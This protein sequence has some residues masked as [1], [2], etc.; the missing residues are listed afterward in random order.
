MLEHPSP[1]PLINICYIWC[2]HD[3]SAHCT[4]WG[5]NTWKL[6][7]LMGQVF[8]LVSFD[9]MHCVR[10]TRQNT[11][12]LWFT[13]L[14]LFHKIWQEVENI[15]FSRKLTNENFW[16]FQICVAISQISCFWK[17]LTP[18]SL[19]TREI[20]GTFH[21]CR[22]KICYLF[23]G[24]KPIL[25]QKNYQEKLSFGNGFIKNPP[26]PLFFLPRVFKYHIKILP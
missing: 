2:H 13:E 19:K 20:P 25:Y 1:F 18:F 12:K 4:R 14:L 6:S 15:Q 21:K 23:S 9:F 7:L 22:F 17:I 10:R 26:V 5:H 16:D 11:V 8:H 3:R 24:L